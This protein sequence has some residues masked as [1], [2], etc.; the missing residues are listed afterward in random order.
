M[1][2]EN[3]MNKKLDE[4]IKILKNE[5]DRIVKEYEID[6]EKLIECLSN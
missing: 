2:G 3:E 4:E 6:I 1:K 5:I